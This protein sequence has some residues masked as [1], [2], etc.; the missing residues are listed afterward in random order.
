VLGF[1]RR[2][3]LI[4]LMAALFAG[5]GIVP[6]QAGNG[7]RYVKVHF[8]GLTWTPNP[9][10]PDTFTGKLTSSNTRCIS[11][12]RVALKEYGP[13]RPFPSESTPAAAVS[14]PDGSFTL[15]AEVKAGYKY[16]VTTLNNPSLGKRRGFKYRCG[17]A[18][19]D[20]PTP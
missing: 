3:L 1:G 11:G 18:F 17:G 20:V 19:N 14:T 2:S 9:A 8:S 5:V 4:A 6:A 12:R 7:I 15:T 16:A 13:E 10:G